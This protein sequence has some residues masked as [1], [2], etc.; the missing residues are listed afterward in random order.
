MR[1][2]YTWDKDS[3]GPQVKYKDIVFPILATQLW[4]QISFLHPHPKGNTY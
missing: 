3:Q 4:Q 1:T 2:L